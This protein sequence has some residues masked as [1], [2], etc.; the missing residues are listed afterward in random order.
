M[1]TFF[2]LAVTVVAA[3]CGAEPELAYSSTLE[4][5]TRGVVL[6][7][8][9]LVAQAA[10]VD[11]T[12]TI[13][14]TW[15][16]AVA[17][18]DLPTEEERVV[19]RYDGWT[20]AVS[21]VG[22]HRFGDSAS[23]ADELALTGVVDARLSDA[24]MV[25]VVADG[26]GC[27]FVGEDGSVA[28]PGGLCAPGIS[29]AAERRVGGLIIGNGE[30]LFHVDLQ[31]AIQISGPAD[32]VVAAPDG[33][34]VAAW[35][36]EPVVRGLDADGEERWTVATDG[37]VRDVAVRG[38]DQI[39]VLV[40]EGE[41]G[42]LERRSLATGERFASYPL[43]SADGS[44]VVSENGRTVGIILPDAVH[45]HSLDLPGEPPV[46]QRDLPRCLFVDTPSDGRWIPRAS[47]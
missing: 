26:S 10:M 42:S 1:R 46:V 11:T 9:G 3:G 23:D 44:L 28:L 29:V 20:L 25:A 14:T 19:D 5:R 31:G 43:P 27:A 8:D 18:L 32:Q 35:R 36:G 6:S 47:D 21:E 45:F 15:G 13:D 40:E 12:C 17:D 24:G 30:G 33:A 37:A 34:L 7:A 2:W 22:L 16:C 39:L 41:A 4:A 38:E